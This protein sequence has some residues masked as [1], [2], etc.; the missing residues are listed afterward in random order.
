MVPLP[1]FHSLPHTMQVTCLDYSSIMIFPLPVSRSQF[2]PLISA[3]H[4]LP[5]LYWE[6]FKPAL[7]THGTA[8]THVVSAPLYSSLQLCFVKRPFHMHTNTQTQ[9]REQHRCA[10][11]TA[12][13]LPQ[14]IEFF[15]CSF[16]L[17]I[18]TFFLP[19]STSSLTRSLGQFPFLSIYFYCIS[20]CRG[21]GGALHPAKCCDQAS[22]AFRCNTLFL[23]CENRHITLTNLRPINHLLQTKSSSK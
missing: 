15:P 19:S 3:G 8:F 7:G 5:S 20:N 13:T 2:A 17:S 18:P 12:S 4:Q 21:L 23:T 16:C 11:T 6:C 22:T 9:K 10:E 14:R 1:L